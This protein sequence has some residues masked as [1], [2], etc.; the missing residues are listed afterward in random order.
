MRFAQ[1]LTD[2]GD[3]INFALDAKNNHPILFTE[4]LGDLVVPNK[5]IKTT[6][7]LAEERPF[8]DSV[9]ATGYLSGT[10]AL[11]SIMGLDQSMPAVDIAAITPT[12]Q[13]NGAGL[14]VLVKFKQGQ[15]KHGSLIDPR[16]PKD[17]DTMDAIVAT[18]TEKALYLA[19]TQEMQR[20]TVNFIV[21]N[22]V[23]LPIGQNCAF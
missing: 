9:G 3:P 15:S 20:Q 10:N 12:Q 17:E 16:H 13:V 4:V 6:D 18:E 8:Y 23:C 7:L 5:A 11:V 14:G 19:V 21:S 2:A 1:T 22:G